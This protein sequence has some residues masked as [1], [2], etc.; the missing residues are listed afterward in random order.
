MKKSN[1]A[2]YEEAKDYCYNRILER[3]NVT[4]KK[5]IALFFLYVII[6]IIFSFF[7]CLFFAGFDLNLVNLKKFFLFYFI[8]TIVFSIFFL[9]KFFILF[10][11]L[12]QKY[13][14]DS[15]RRKCCCKPSCSEYS[16]LVIAHYG[17]I[18]GSI[19]AFKRMFITCSGESFYID[20]PKFYKGK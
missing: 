9:R 6:K 14:S 12:Y 11:Q 10:I 1:P 15:T 19:M 8:V 3:P 7:S 17:A 4:Y 18:I 13:A 20:Y 16:I 2:E 5:V